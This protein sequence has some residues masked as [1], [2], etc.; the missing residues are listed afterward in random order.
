MTIRFKYVYPFAILFLFLYPILTTAQVKINPV[1]K[2]PVVV[3]VVWHDKDDLWSINE[4]KDLIYHLNDSYALHDSDKKRVRKE[5]HQ[6]MA[7]PG[8][9]FDLTETN[10]LGLSY[11][12]VTFTHTD[13]EFFTKKELM[14]VKFDSTGGKSAWPVKEYLNIWVCN[15]QPSKDG[16]Q[17]TGHST[18]PQFD[19]HAEYD[20]IVLSN[21]HS[22]I[23]SAIVHESGHYLGLPHPWGDEAGKGCAGDDGFTDTPPVNG[24]SN[25]GRKTSPCDVTVL[26]ENFMDFNACGAMF[27][28]EQATYMRRILNTQRAKLHKNKVKYKEIIGLPDEF[29]IHGTKLKKEKLGYSIKTL[30]TKKASFDIPSSDFYNTLSLKKKDLKFLQ[31]IQDINT[32]DQNTVLRFYFLSE[33]NQWNLIR[34][35]NF[36]PKLTNEIIYNTLKPYKKGLIRIKTFPKSSQKRVHNYGQ[37]ID[38]VVE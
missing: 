20:G 32:L 35:L 26:W 4:V 34:E 29:P 28:K 24:P 31:I 5:F 9:R 16:T 33:E 1:I 23:R 17:T 7:D 27:T 2:V 12:R 21:D 19:L 38:L 8:I 10:E 13:K 22:T 15:I 6:V 30:K 37:L 3:H 11:P 36:D 18:R 25:C 14:E